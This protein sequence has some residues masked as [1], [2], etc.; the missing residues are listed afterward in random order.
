MARTIKAQANSV[1]GFPQPIQAFDLIPETFERAPT[2]SDIGF[3]LG[4][5]WYDSVGQINYILTSVAAGSATWVATVAAVGPVD[6]IQGSSGGALS[7][8]AGNIIIAA[9]A[10][11]ASTAGAGHTIT[12]NGSSTPTFTKVT[13]GTGAAGITG[14]ATLSG[15]TI[16]VSTT[17][18]T[19]ASKIQLTVN[20][21]DVIANLGFLSAPTASIIAATSFVINSSN[22]ADGSTVNWLIIN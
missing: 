9:G 11:I 1:Y 22:A 2:T 13:L 8:A 18:V 6:T 15:G 5:Q 21:P 3:S 17:G 14:T 12:V 10:N 16:T 20:T 19:A 7:P 4:Q